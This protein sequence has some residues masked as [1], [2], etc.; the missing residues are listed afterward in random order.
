M[1]GGAAAPFIATIC[2]RVRCPLPGARF[3]SPSRVAPAMAGLC[4][5]HPHETEATRLPNTCMMHACMSR[6][7]PGM[8]ECVLSGFAAKKKGAS[9]LEIRCITVITRKLQEQLLVCNSAYDLSSSSGVKPF[10]AALLLPKAL[11]TVTFLPRPR[12]YGCA[13]NSECRVSSACDLAY[14]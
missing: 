14:Y 6:L 1:P 2:R 12:T 11:C 7:Q 8:W 3:P 10:V 13:Q 5:R 9:S 4:A